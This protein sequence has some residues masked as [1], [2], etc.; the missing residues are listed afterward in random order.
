MSDTLSCGHPQFIAR[1]I[2]WGLQKSVLLVAVIF[3]GLLDLSTASFQ[4]VGAGRSEWNINASV[5]FGQSAV[6]SGDGSALGILMRT[7]I[8]AAFLEHN[9]EGG[10]SLG[11]IS[12]DDLYT[13]PHSLDNTQQL[14]D[15]DKVFALIGQVGTPT[16]KESAPFAVNRS[17]PFIGAF[18]GAM[19]LREP[20][21]RYIVNYRAS[22]IDECAAMI[23]YF[24]G[25]RQLSRVS[26]YRQDDSFGD[27]VKEGVTRSLRQRRLQI[28]SEAKFSKSKFNVTQGFQDLAG[29]TEDPPDAVVLVGT[30]AV[31]HLFVKEAKK[32]W[33]STL[34]STVSFVGPTT[35]S[36]FLE[37]PENRENVFITQTVP[38]PEDTSI[39]IVRKYHTALKDWERETGDESKP[40]FTSFE[41]YLVGTMAA[42]LVKQVTEK[43][44]SEITKNQ[45]KFR[46]LFLDEVYD[47]GIISV[48][49]DTGGGARTGRDVFRLGP[50]GGFCDQIGTGCNCNQGQRQV[51]GTM[52]NPD[53]TF[54]SFPQMDFV[55]STCGYKDSQ[56]MYKVVFGQ[57]AALSGPNQGL[58]ESME[59]GIR[60]AFAQV[61]KSADLLLEPSLHS[62]DDAYSPDKTTSNMK[63]LLDKEHVFALVGA[64]GTPTS[65]AALDVLEDHTGVPFIGPFT[66]AGFL[67]NPWKRDVIN[68]RASYTD[69]CAAMVHYYTQKKGFT[70][71]SLFM[72]DDGYGAAGLTGLDIALR[73]YGLNIHS[74]GRYQ[75]LY[76][77][78]DE[79]MPLYACDCTGA[80]PSLNVTGAVDTL[81]ATKPQAIVMFATGS[82]TTLFIPEMLDRCP[83]C[84]FAAVS[85]VG[86][87]YLRNNLKAELSKNVIM[88]QV[89]PLYTDTN[90]TL[91][92]DYQNAM[93]HLF[94]DQINSR[95]PSRREPEYNFVSLEGYIVGSLV[96]KVLSRL[97]TS[98]RQ[99]FIDALY[100]TKIID[101][102]DDKTFR[103]GPYLREEAGIEGCNQGMHTVFLTKMEGA[104]FLS[105]P[106]FP[107][108]SF[109]NLCGLTG[110]NIQCYQGKNFSGEFQQLY[111]EFQNETCKACNPGSRSTGKKCI[112]CQPGT[113]WEAGK[114]IDC[115]PGYFSNEMSRTVPCSFCPAGRYQSKAASTKC[116]EC[117]KGEWREDSDLADSC[118]PC[119]VGKYRPSHEKV[120]C[121]LCPTNSFAENEGA[122]QCT[123]CDAV[124]LKAVTK[125]KGATSPADCECAPGYYGTRLGASGN[126]SGLCAY[127]GPDLGRGSGLHC[128]GGKT[129]NGSAITTGAHRTG[130]AVLQSFM[131]YPPVKSSDELPVHLNIYA[132]AKREACPGTYKIWDLSSLCAAGRIGIA[133]GRC[134]EHHYR[135]SGRCDLCS[136][137]AAISVLTLVFV[138]P[139]LA[140]LIYR[141]ATKIRE[142]DVLLKEAKRS[143]AALSSEAPTADEPSPPLA[144]DDQ[145]CELSRLRA[146]APS[147]I[148]RTF[149]MLG[150]FKKE[151]LDVVASIFK[152]LLDFTQTLGVVMPLFVPLDLGSDGP[153]TIKEFIA[154]SSYLS[155]QFES[156]NEHLHIDCLT[157]PDFTNIYMVEMCGPLYLCMCL[158]CNWAFH[159]LVMRPLVDLVISRCSAKKI[160]PYFLNLVRSMV[161][162][163]WDSTLNLCGHLMTSFY[164]SL[165]S[166]TLAVSVTYSH[167]GQGDGEQ[168]AGGRSMQR[169]PQTLVNSDEWKQ[170]L[171][172]S[173]FMFAFYC[174][175]TLVVS[176]WACFTAPKWMSDPSRC[177]ACAFLTGQFHPSV[178]WWSIVLLLRGLFWNICIIL[179]PTSQIAGVMLIVTFAVYLALNFYWRPW[180]GNHAFLK[181]IVDIC[182][183]LMICIIVPAMSLR[184]QYTEVVINNSKEVI[185][186]AEGSGV[187]APVV[188]VFVLMMVPVHVFLT[189][190]RHAVAIYHTSQHFKLLLML[191][192]RADRKTLDNFWYGLNDTDHAI[193]V[194]TMHVFYAEVLRVQPNGHI[195]GQRLIHEA[196]E[197]RIADDAQVL[198]QVENDLLAGKDDL[199]TLHERALVQWV[200]EQLIVGYHNVMTQRSKS[201]P[202]GSAAL[203]YDDLDITVGTP[204][205]R[206]RKNKCSSCLKQSQVAIRR[207]LLHQRDK[208]SIRGLYHEME[209]DGDNVIEMQEFVEAGRRLAPL[210]L[211]HELEACFKLLDGEGVGFFDEDRFAL[212]FKGMT[213]R[214]SWACNKK[215]RR[216][217][218]RLSMKSPGGQQ[219]IERWSRSSRAY[220]I[221]VTMQRRFRARKAQ[222]IE[223]SISGEIL[224]WGPSQQSSRHCVD[225]ARATEI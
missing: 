79:S 98:S 117:A 191:I 186:W 3:V 126:A 125:F 101:I 209:K 62:M 121:K 24:T 41:G 81:Y 6:F 19:L 25:T 153:P 187:I 47:R 95:G 49:P 54:S 211:P 213:F 205:Q 175:G 120:G 189:R 136:G 110:E 203:R 23:Q 74:I 5:V 44:G 142:P 29:Q 103:L 37:T 87:E 119:D 115:I 97:A 199:A 31:L 105:V 60:A 34:F 204:K 35:F 104:R 200:L 155:M 167:P 27:A 16:S 176:M 57:S 50:F 193:M 172:V 56:N 135:L 182:C 220:R 224:D 164:I 75:P 14:I 159:K 168:G 210:V 42:L 137:D 114:C 214:G 143:S 149:R 218:L 72:Q 111:R 171:P 102:T 88:T 46:E 151:V 116:E 100:E 40:D 147:G 131:V 157:G 127:C 178:W 134:P 158:I 196:E 48:Q 86:S 17:V 18:T 190:K 188:S 174:I 133:C 30:Y 96:V 162:V 73:A 65:R 144:K 4:T 12:Y 36:E 38:F 215:A 181:N 89:T 169:F 80:S 163:R 197:F 99:R 161:D 26:L 93:K 177:R 15:V 198:R 221:I 148:A 183:N 28:Y 70:K 223:V 139:A 179:S 91:I 92:R 63:H 123:S 129:K 206:E 53:G 7:G 20:F 156:I 43:M 11:L 138:G 222:R 195:L 22:Y 2:N 33:K 150:V 160:T 9:K 90:L 128:P 208:V 173:L 1:V 216:T 185:E 69:E 154:L 113:Y 118:K 170:M 52:I 109:P 8:Q 152:I 76:A 83:A 55:F 146:S 61:A 217:L 207:S 124:L 130:P 77:C 225:N 67:R 58:G 10:V 66:G 108:I 140:F 94:D 71:I 13:G 59:L 212:I 82:A 192:T 201:Q 122:T 184:A 45:T 202:D 107:N 39:P 141:L 78:C 21:T 132:C 84:Q 64:V 180:G 32:K 85:F 112:P 219:T 106:E 166:L 68:V 165:V 145:M 51:Y 194:Y